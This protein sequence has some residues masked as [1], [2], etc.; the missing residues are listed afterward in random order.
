MTKHRFHP[1]KRQKRHFRNLQMAVVAA[2]TDMNSRG[3][4]GTDGEYPLMPN[5][6]G[7]RW[8]GFPPTIVTKLKYC[9]LFTKTPSVA[10]NHQVFNLNSI[11][12]PDES[13]VGHQ[14]L[15]RDT[16]ASIYNYYTVLGSKIT[17]TFVNAAA[18][19]IPAVVGIAVGDDSTFV[20]TLSQLLE[21]NKTQ[22]KLLGFNTGGNDAVI[23]TNTYGTEAD[24]GIDPLSGSS[25]VRTAIGSNPSELYC[26]SVFAASA[27]GAT[28]TKVWYTIEIEYTV[29]FS[30]L[31]DIGQS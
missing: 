16:F 30:E 10:I 3:K 8:F 19:A 26:A 13:G 11:Y 14:P 6:F 18:T 5:I 29:A 25:N 28:A 22:Y 15:Y 9:E 2:D 12:D 21:Y 4:R 1:Y 23:L 17:V 20:T 31:A 7:T 24:E 27:D